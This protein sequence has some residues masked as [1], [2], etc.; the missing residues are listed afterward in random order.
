[1]N[2]E[3]ELY[4]YVIKDATVKT[5]IEAYLKRSN[6]GLEKY[7]TSLAKNDLPLLEWL[8]H[9]QMELMDCVLYLQRAIDEIEDLN[10][11]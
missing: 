7:G 6:V 8:K 4:S 5:V 11:V 3:K 1:M 9:S 10:N 2:P